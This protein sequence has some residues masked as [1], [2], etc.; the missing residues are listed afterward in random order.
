MHRFPYLWWEDHG[1]QHAFKPCPWLILAALVL[2]SL[3]APILAELCP[4]SLQ[5]SSYPVLAVAVPVSELTKRWRP[6]RLI[7]HTERDG[8]NGLR[9]VVHFVALL[10]YAR[11][12][13][14]SATFRRNT[15]CERERR[16]YRSGPVAQ[17]GWLSQVS[18]RHQLGI[19]SN[20][21]TVRLLRCAVMWPLVAFCLSARR[22]SRATRMGQ[23]EATLRWPMRW[24]YTWRSAS[25]QKSGE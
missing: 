21:P 10:C 16:G 3:P 1:V 20:L 17:L 23:H 19:R 5:A 7:T 18:D 11:V 9:V 13:Q 22:L 24:G 4:P 14:G 25:L 8:H 2:S 12:P 6:C 15:V